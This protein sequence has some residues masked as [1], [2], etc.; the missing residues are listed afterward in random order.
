MELV[1]Q[2]LTP[3]TIVGTAGAA[4]TVRHLY[5]QAVSMAEDYE[6]QAREMASEELYDEI[7]AMNAGYM[8]GEEEPLDEDYAVLDLLRPRTTHRKQRFAEVY[9]ERRKE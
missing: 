6:E 1:E 5:G 7:K 4:A 8:I 9:N 3:A 2:L